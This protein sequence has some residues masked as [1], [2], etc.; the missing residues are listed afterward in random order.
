MSR[1]HD[2]RAHTLMMKQG[3][4]FLQ[5]VQGVFRYDDLHGQ[6]LTALSEPAEIRQQMEVVVSLI[7]ADVQVMQR[8][9]ARAHV[10]VIRMDAAGSGLRDE[11]FVPGICQDL[12]QVLAKKRFPPFETDHEY[13][14]SGE[15]VQ[16]AQHIGRGQLRLRW[17][18]PHIA[19]VALHTAAVGYFEGSV[20]RINVFSAAHIRE[21]TADGL[22]YFLYSSRLHTPV[23]S[24][25]GWRIEMKAA[26]Q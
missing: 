15:V 7:D 24:Q 4:F 18:F 23:G 11:S 8:L 19:E 22:E 17:T 16:N 21:R 13:A 6:L 14:R 5:R 9:A 3:D 25:P 1:G 2:N 26:D 20:K 12:G 10:C